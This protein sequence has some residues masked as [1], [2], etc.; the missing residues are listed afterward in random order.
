[1][2]LKL[3][4]VM[5]RIQKMQQNVQAG[6]SVICM[7]YRG[8]GSSKSLSKSGEEVR[9]YPSEQSVYQ[10]GKDMLHYVVDKDK[11]NVKPEN[12][13]LHGFSLGGAVA[14]KV[15]ADF[16][17]EQQKQALEQGKTAHKLGGIVLHSS[18][19]KLADVATRQKNCVMGFGGWAFGGGYNTKSHLQRLHRLDPDIPVHYVSGSKDATDDYDR[20]DP[21][22]L[23]LNVT[24]LH[25]DPKAQFRN[26]SVQ[27]GDESHTGMNLRAIDILPIVQHG[28]EAQLGGPERGLA[29]QGQEPQLV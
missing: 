22:N 3:D 11:L 4:E 24:K 5:Q 18:I 1:M 15:A 12:V 19:D 16:T 23:D 29:P 7:D 27:I 8:F 2:P 6:A 14:S 25:Q 28:R 26:S 13:I 10:D 9:T 21:D 17:Q 20:P